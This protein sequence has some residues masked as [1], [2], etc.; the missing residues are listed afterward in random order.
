MIKTRPLSFV[1]LCF[2]LIQIIIMIVSGEDSITDIP[3]GSVFYGKKEQTVI[4]HGQ[5]YKKTNTS[6][7]QILYLKNNSTNDSKIMVYDENFTEV[8]IGQT[9]LLQGRTKLFD[10]S[11]NPGNFDQRAYYAKQNVHG[12]IWCDKVVSV[13]GDSRWVPERLHQMKRHWKNMILEAIGEKDGNILT[14]MLLGERGDMESDIKELY[15]RNGIGHILA[16]SGLHISFIGL[17]IY[18][19]IRKIGVGYIPSGILSI[20]ILTLY[21]LMIGFS[22]SVIRAYVML[23]FRIGADMTG[24]VYDMLTAL[25]VAAAITVGIQP[26]YLT[27][28]AF[29]LSYG[30]ILGIIFILPFMENLFPC[31]VNFLSVFRTSLAIHVMLFPIILLFYFEVPTYSMVLNCMIIPMTSI[32]LGVGMMGSLFCLI[33]WPLGNLCLQVCKLILWVFEILST[34]GSKLPFWRVVIGQPKL[35]QVVVYYFMLIICIVVFQQCVKHKKMRLARLLLCTCMGLSTLLLVYRPQG[36][37]T[38]TMLDVGQGDA[39]FIRG[40]EGN[41][42][43]I[44]GGSSDVEQLGKYRIEPFLKSQGVGELDYVFLT[45][46]DTDH[47][48]GIKEMLGRQDLGV[49]IKHLVLPIN[50]KQDDT[51][52][53]LAQ[54]AQNEEVSVSVME[55]GK[56]MIEGDLQLKCIQPALGD[57]NLNGNEG[58]IVLSVCFREFSMLCTGDV[59]AKGEELLTTRLVGQKFTVLKVAHHGSKNSSSERFLKAIRPEIALLSAGKNNSYGHPHHESLERLKAIGCNIFTTTKNGAITLQTDGNTLTIDRF[60]Y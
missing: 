6:N 16:I 42:Y 50:W 35:W 44:D 41:T 17:G 59:E 9:L 55:A 20:F 56:Y 10:C 29:L 47:C 34:V 30:A 51:L 37:L 24:R 33:L 8:A 49:R 25:L 22:V 48:N 45:H 28:A 43:L 14:A 27:D 31:R 21:G 23:L 39:I 53:E 38:V 18:K 54:I 4:I 12:I 2:L 60:L 52:V 19:F 32:L 26:L 13:T 36:N 7:I 3:T 46:G 5:V 11:R 58:S 15:Q 1:C 57:S 40:P